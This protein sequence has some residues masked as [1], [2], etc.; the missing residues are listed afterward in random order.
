ML[1]KLTTPQIVVI[2]S[3]MRARSLIDRRITLAPNAFVELVVWELPEPL[4][5][6]T[7]GYK[8]RFALVVRDECVLRHDNEAG[9]GDHVHLGTIERPYLFVDIDRL[10]ADFLADAKEWLNDNRYP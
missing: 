2:V 6:S 8:Y 9:K 5:G 10:T 7:H 1:D 4:K 3:N